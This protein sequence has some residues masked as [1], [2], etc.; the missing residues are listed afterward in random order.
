MASTKKDP[1]PPTF[2][3]SP[4]KKGE[5]LY[6]SPTMRMCPG[7][8]D[9]K[10]IHNLLEFKRHDHKAEMYSV[11]CRKCIVRDYEIEQSRTDTESV[12]TLT[13]ALAKA[14]KRRV[15]GPSFADVLDYTCAPLG[16]TDK[17][18]EMTGQ[19]FHRV[20]TK[21]MREEATKDDL[22]RAVKVGSTLITSA[23]TCEKTKGPPIDISSLTQDELQ[24]IM[25]EPARQLILSDAEF[26]RQLLNDDSIRKALLGDLGVA[27]VETTANPVTSEDEV[28][29]QELA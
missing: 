26:R 22:D 1:T 5:P 19:V 14:T 12:K 21:A 28:W 27:V 4:H 6:V 13:A 15:A 9:D 17:A 2:E 10:N 20:M 16:G 7:C 29:P 3:W 18:F 8:P 25:A 23:A 24:M 11:V